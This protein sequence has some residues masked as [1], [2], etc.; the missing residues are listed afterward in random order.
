M[1]W[2]D[3]QQWE[4][5]PLQAYAADCEYKQRKLQAAGDALGQRLDSLLG[6]GQ[7]VKAAKAALRKQIFVI[8]K[9]VNFLISSAEIASEGAQGINEIRAN[10]DDAKQLAHSWNMT[11]DSSGNVSIDAAQVKR[12][13]MVGKNI[14]EIRHMVDIAQKRVNTALKRAQELVD[15]LSRKS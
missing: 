6:S 4:S 9:E 3:I 7:T 11:I 5:A 14:L 10:V 15:S 1:K 12:L 2:T 13:K 8:E